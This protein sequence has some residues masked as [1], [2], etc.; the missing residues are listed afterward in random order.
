MKRIPRINEIT[1]RALTDPE[2]SFVSL[3]QGG[4]NQRPFRSVKNAQAKDETRSVS[5]SERWGLPKGET[6]STPEA[7]RA[8]RCNQLASALGGCITSFNDE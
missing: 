7:T 1:A 5:L 6:F 2:P 3:V 4:A 8:Q